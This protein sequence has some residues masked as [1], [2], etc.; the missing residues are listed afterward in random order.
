MQVG[1]LPFKAGPGDTVLHCQVFRSR[2]GWLFPIRGKWESWLLEKSG[3]LRLG[4]GASKAF[5][6]ME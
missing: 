1:I 6:V 3:C 4:V 5:Y 2:L